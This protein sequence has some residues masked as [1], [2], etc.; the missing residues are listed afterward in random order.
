MFFVCLKKYITNLNEHLYCHYTLHYKQQQCYVTIG[1]L[2]ESPVL[3]GS[4]LS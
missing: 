3:S 4:L 1:L 2:G